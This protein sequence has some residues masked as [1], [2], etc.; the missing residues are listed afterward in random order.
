MQE[1]SNPQSAGNTTDT[2]DATTVV[3]DG[4]PGAWA[5]GLDADGE[6]AQD[7]GRSAVGNASD[8]D[9]DEREWGPVRESRRGRRG[10]GRHT[11]SR[12][13]IAAQEREAGRH[14]ARA[15]AGR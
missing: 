9:P 4:T 3:V 14:I 5:D 11:R 7:A 12:R 15:L 8:G 10:G 1:H 2:G 6:L 13:A